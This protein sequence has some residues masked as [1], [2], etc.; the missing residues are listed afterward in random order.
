MLNIDTLSKQFGCETVLT[1]INFEVT[2][3]IIHALIGPNGSGKTTLTKIVA[4]LLAPT[5]GTV[6]VN[7]QDI[8]Q[9]PEET[10][11][12]IGY[13]P[14]NP[15][16]WGKMT[17]REFLHFVG[18]LYGMTPAIRSKRIAE[19]L[20]LFQLESIADR[21]FEHYSRGNRQKF[22]IIAAWLHKPELLLIDEPIVGLDPESVTTFEHI[23]QDFAQAG[24]AVLITTHTLLV[25]EHIA[26]TV[27][28]LAHGKLVANNSLS[29][30]R[31]EAGEAEDA[32]LAKVYHALVKGDVASEEATSN[33]L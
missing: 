1:D 14:D 2:K 15:E 18:A 32:S 33:V 13:I 12:V 30:L 24:G 31:S 11:Q 19:L 23:L 10:K 26:D 27:G 4:G 20:P 3:G 28:L 22:A 29:Q 25:A 17:G 6:T 21:Y 8:A 16:A 7:G 5:S 9:K